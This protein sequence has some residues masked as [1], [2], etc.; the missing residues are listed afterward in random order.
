MRCKRAAPIEPILEVAGICDQSPW[1]RWR[2]QG[3][4]LAQ[5]PPTSVG[6]LQMPACPWQYAESLVL[7]PGVVLRVL[8]ALSSIRQEADHPRTG[9][10]R[11][12]SRPAQVPHR[13]RGCRVEAYHGKPRKAR[14]GV[15]AAPRPGQ[16]H[17][18]PAASRTAGLRRVMRLERL[19]PR[20]RIRRLG[21]R[22]PMPA[23][24]WPEEEVRARSPPATRSWRRYSR[25]SRRGSERPSSE[26]T[27][28]RSSL[29]GC[30]VRETG[31]HGEL[32]PSRQ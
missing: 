15:P 31:V 17:T 25:S 24:S 26:T 6:S 12:S 19:S 30:V 27:G 21:R 3:P 14:C 1:S 20:T 23:P 10:E 7:R 4:L 22:K 18:P 9:S 13:T 32:A 5:D 2:R 8:S 16:R 29:S 11:G 28:R